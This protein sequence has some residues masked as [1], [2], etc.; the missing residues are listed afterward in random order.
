[1]FPFDMMA[2]C[3]VPASHIELERCGYVS[4]A[5]QREIFSRMLQQVA[6]VVQSRHCTSIRRK[7]AGQL[8]VPEK[9]CI[10]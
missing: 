4:L 9:I 7:R 8:P 5:V 6:K 2:Y 10:G 3:N 1:M